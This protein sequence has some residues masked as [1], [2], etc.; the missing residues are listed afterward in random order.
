MENY[1]QDFDGIYLELCEKIST[2]P[3]NEWIDLWHNQVSFLDEEHPFPTPATFIAFRIVDT[4]DGGEKAQ[5][6]K[7]QIDLYHFF[8]TFADTYNGSYNQSSAMDF[9][10]NC[11]QAYQL[12]HATDGDT[13]TNMRRVAFAPVDTGSGGNLYRQSFTCMARDLSAMKEY[14]SVIPGDVSIL[15]EDAPIAATGNNAY[16]IG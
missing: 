16:K 10:R 13:W 6:L 11:K 4:E 15:K 8:E 7:I 2:L 5:D 9:L 1:T 14:N 3:D 12:L